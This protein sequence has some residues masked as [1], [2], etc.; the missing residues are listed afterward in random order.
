M[1]T[2]IEIIIGAVVLLAIIAGILTKGGVFRSLH[3]KSLAAA[4][5]FNESIRDPMADGRAAIAKAREDLTGMKQ[6]LNDLLVQIREL[7]E[8]RDQ[9]ARDV[10]KYEN[11]AK[12]AGL[13]G[14]AADVQTALTFKLAAEK[15]VSDFDA[16]MTK[17]DDLAKSIRAMIA[18]QTA[19]IEGAERDSKYLGTSLKH[20]NMRTKIAESVSDLEGTKQ[21]LHRLRQDAKR[22]QA[23]AEVSESESRT[24]SLADN[25]ENKYASTAP[26]ISEETIAKYMKKAAE[27]T[28]AS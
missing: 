3:N 22:A 7:K 12:A 23:Q 11:L 13:A 20:N 6:Q 1:L 9:A 28:P 8:D 2:L 16:E 18:S 21:S 17:S 24:G 14:N 4:E 27:P 26:A 25:L 10:F 15:E 5:D 19:E